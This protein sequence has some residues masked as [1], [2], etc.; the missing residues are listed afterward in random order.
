MCRQW[1]DDPLPLGGLRDR[2]RH[3][4]SGRHVTDAQAAHRRPAG[5]ARVARRGR[6]RRE[7]RG[8]SAGGDPLAGR[9]GWC[10]QRAGQHVE[11]V[12]E[13]PGHDRALHASGHADRVRRHTRLTALSR[14]DPACDGGLRRRLHSGGKQGLA[15]RPVGLPGPILS[16]RAGCLGGQL[17]SRRCRDH[18]RQ[19]AGGGA[20]PPEH[21]R[22]RRLRR[23]ARPHGLHGRLERRAR[24]VGHGD[25]PRDPRHRYRHERDQ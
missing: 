17:F 24:R 9:G 14:H 11:P 25:G 15:D 23:C 22:R 6:R 12:R 7:P 13:R 16:D 1:H 2:S 8:V 19:R 3:L 10:D 20:L 18:R 21:A 5:R 4:P